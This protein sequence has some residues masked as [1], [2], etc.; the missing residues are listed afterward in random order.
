MR[1]F[2][3]TALSLT[4]GLA[5]TALSS[6]QKDI[7]DGPSSTSPPKTS[8][9]LTVGLPP[10][11]VWWGNGPNL[12]FS[13]GEP[14]DTPDGDEY[15]LGFA[16]NG[17]G[18]IVGSVLYDSHG[19]PE[20]IHNMF[21]FDIPTQSWIEVAPMP[22]LPPVQASCFVIGDDAYVINASS[23]VTYRYHQP[24]NTWSTV[25]TIPAK[26]DR[27]RATA[28][29]INGKG[30]VGLGDGDNASGNPSFSSDWWEYDPATD[31]WTQKHNFPGGK[32]I[33]AAGFAVDGK[34]YVCSGQKISGGNYSYPNDLWQYDPATDT[35]VQKADMP[36]PGLAAVGLD[37]IVNGGIHYGFVVAGGPHGC[38][39]YNP[40]TD[41]WG[42][43]PDMLGGS[44]YDFAA[45]MINR[46]LFIGGG[47]G[48]FGYS[49][50]RMDV[51][52]LNWSK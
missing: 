1:T 41:A 18:Y 21:R 36:G 29:A 25:A 22:G 52:F 34:G 46:S 13:D 42:I 47:V 45:F 27:F 38:L 7:L 44:R 14:G 40:A 5:A 20:S 17:V 15:P 10:T 2:S 37:G 28:F 30:Y 51:C 48:G 23:K 35:W 8:A 11:I 50:A 9:S 16:I 43:L 32:R 31:A 26:P 33:N 24:T 6:C 39:Q 12:P 49:P 19:A 4:A 3:W